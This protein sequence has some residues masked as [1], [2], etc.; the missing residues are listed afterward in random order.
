ML[1]TNPLARRSWSRELV[2]S[3]S[4]GWWLLLLNGIVSIVAG[5]IILLVDWSLNDLAFFLGVLFIVEAARHGLEV[6]GHRPPRPGHADRLQQHRP[7]D[8]LLVDDGLRPPR[9]HV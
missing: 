3:V 9:R 6:A 2:R 1:V 8:E 7:E 4:S 5:G